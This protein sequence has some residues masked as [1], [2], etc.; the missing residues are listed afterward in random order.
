MSRRLLT[1][2]SLLPLLACATAPDDAVPVPIEV[3]KGPISPVVMDG[4]SNSAPVEGARVT[5]RSGLVQRS[6]RTDAT[7]AALAQISPGTY[8][9]RVTECPGALALPAPETVT[10]APG[11]DTRIQLECDTGIR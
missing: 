2:F 10:V 6:Y 4:E 5:L 9:V 7:G 3:R 1:A 8:E 11:G